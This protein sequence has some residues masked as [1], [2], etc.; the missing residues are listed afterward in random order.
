MGIAETLIVLTVLSPVIALVTWGVC[1]V[2]R[3]R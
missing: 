3:K 2:V 1:A